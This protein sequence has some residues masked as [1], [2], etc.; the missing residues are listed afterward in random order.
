M[1]ALLLRKNFIFT[2]FTFYWLVFSFGEKLLKLSILL[3][4]RLYLN[5]LLSDKNSTM[6]RLLSSF[7][8]LQIH[9]SH[10]MI[11]RFHWEPLEGN[12]YCQKFAEVNSKQ[13][14]KQGSQRRI[15]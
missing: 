11:S 15:F 14:V 4:T 13:N 3:K 2:K 9:H 7:H 8:F 10:Q 12:G 1:N 6:A 5:I